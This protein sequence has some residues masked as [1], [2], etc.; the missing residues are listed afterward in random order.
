MGLT[1]CRKNWTKKST[2]LMIF[3]KK[4]ECGN[5]MLT[6][7]IVNEKDLKVGQGQPQNVKETHQKAKRVDR[8]LN[9]ER[10]LVQRNAQSPGQN[11]LQL[12]RSEINHNPKLNLRKRKKKQRRKKKK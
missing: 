4:K 5:I 2:R 1:K 11:P 10:G 6:T 3:V 12:K 8:G 7:K 9:R